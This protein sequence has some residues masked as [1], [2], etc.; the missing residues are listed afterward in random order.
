MINI[1]TNITPE[2]FQTYLDYAPC[3]SEPN[4]ENFFMPCL[5]LKTDEG[6]KEIIISDETYYNPLTVDSNNVSISASIY[7][8]YHP[9]GIKYPVCNG[10]SI[11]PDRKA[12]KETIYSGGRYVIEATYTY[13]VDD[14]TYSKK[15]EFVI[16]VDC[17]KEDIE[18]IINTIKHK[19]KDVSCKINSYEII[20]KNTNELYNS[21]YLLE[22]AL[23]L[24]STSKAQDYCNDAEIVNCFLSTLKNIC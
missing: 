21:L 7:Y 22:N 23:F 6:C 13:V 18:S 10:F 20:G 9:Y 15:Y 24:L 16:D 19:I 5:I 3:V 17:C 12:Y 1:T 11:Q 4:L 14:V 2:I 8:Q